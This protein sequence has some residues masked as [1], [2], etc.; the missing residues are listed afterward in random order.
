MRVCVCQHTNKC[1]GC[2]VFNLVATTY[3]HRGTVWL[4]AVFRSA[5]LHEVI[6]DGELVEPTVDDGLPSRVEVDPVWAE[7]EI[8][9][10]RDDDI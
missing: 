9:R 5:E 1:F 6:A 4:D 3:G 2:Q 7:D 10:L 8:E